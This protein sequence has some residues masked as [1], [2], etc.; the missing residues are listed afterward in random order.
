M[1]KIIIIFETH[2][3]AN[4][5]KDYSVVKTSKAG[6]QFLAFFYT[7]INNTFYLLATF[8]S[9]LF[10]TLIQKP[11][12]RANTVLSYIASAFMAGK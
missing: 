5:N 9:L 4:H 3:E 1:Y 7:K 8:T 2:F 6:E 11:L 10:T 12:V